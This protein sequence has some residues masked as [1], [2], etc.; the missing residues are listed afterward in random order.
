MYIYGNIT[1]ERVQL[2]N[3]DYAY[4]LERFKIYLKQNRPIL[5]N[6]ILFHKANARLHTCVVTMAKIHELLLPYPAYTPDLA[7]IMIRAFKCQEMA[8]G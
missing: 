7:P 6:K 2:Y 5:K 8:W 4:I 1:R 3:S